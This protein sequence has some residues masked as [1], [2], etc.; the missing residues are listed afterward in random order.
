MA[1]PFFNRKCLLLTWWGRGVNF[2]HP[3]TTQI[4]PCVVVVILVIIVV[5]VVVVVVGVTMNW[6]IPQ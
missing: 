5:V 2:I 4:I 1:H 6:T 3:F